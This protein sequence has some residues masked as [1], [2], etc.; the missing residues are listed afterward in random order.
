[1]ALEI[2]PLD[3]AELPAA[4]RIFRLAFGTF[5]G[6]EDPSSFA[7]DTD[8][9][10]GRWRADPRANFAARRDGEVIGSNFAAPWGS[11]ATFGP[12]SVHPDLWG[13][14]VARRLL[15]PTMALF[16]RWGV[17]HA[18][19]FTFSNSPK[20]VALYQKFDFWPGALTAILSLGVPRAGSGGGAPDPSAQRFSR[21]APDDRA[22]ALR[23]CRE[24]TDG[25][26]EGLDVS[27]EIDVVVRAGLGETVL[28][29][30]GAGRVESIA[31]CHVGARTE[32]GS[33][34]TYVKFGA[35]RSGAGAAERFAR[36]L[37]ECERL[38]AE[39]GTPRLVAGVS[40][41]RIGAYRELL[42]RGFRTE[43][44]GVAMHRGADPAYNRSDAWILD[45]WR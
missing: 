5:V 16:E 25:V 39:R 11:L 9:V 12:L 42:A 2:S 7:G 34:C 4:D 20:H 29:R 23:D 24:M 1:M 19:L 32:A 3:E 28:V 18:G 22:A 31:V 37:D 26:L 45:D 41:A 38:A 14:G 30:D 43:I 15:E 8:Y 40:T 17:R 13:E 10:H 44:L 36:L 6:L 33:G 35:A 27:R 21:L